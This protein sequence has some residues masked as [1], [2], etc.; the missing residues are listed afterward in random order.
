M[1]GGDI[2]FVHISFKNGVNP[3]LKSCKDRQELEREI[4]KWSEK[5]DLKPLKCTMPGKGYFFEAT[6]KKS[7][8]EK[9]KDGKNF[10]WEKGGET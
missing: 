9:V 3:Y 5:Y 1:I 6:E 7:I 8:I 2:L 10:I 4:N